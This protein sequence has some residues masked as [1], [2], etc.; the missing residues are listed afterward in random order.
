MPCVKDRLG[1]GDFL[2][3]KHTSE[4]APESVEKRLTVHG[5]PHVSSVR[6]ERRRC[7]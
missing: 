6:K 1:A 2:W 4:A 3:L 5:L 7:D